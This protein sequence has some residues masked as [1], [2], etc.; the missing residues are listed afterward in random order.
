MDVVCVIC[1]GTHSCILLINACANN[2]PIFQSAYDSIR[3]SEKNDIHSAITSSLSI[4]QS[5]FLT[6]CLLIY[7][8]LSYKSLLY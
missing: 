3:I 4:A 7:K 1:D 6:L 8:H 5:R 2:V